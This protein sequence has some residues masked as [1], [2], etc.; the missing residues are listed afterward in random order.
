MKNKIIPT[1]FA[2][3]NKTFNS[4]L[5]KL[6]FSKNIHLDFMDKTFTDNKTVQIKEMK[7]IS[8]YTNIN[9]EIH[10]MTKNPLKY[11]KEIKELNIKKV[12][13][14]EEVSGSEKEI[15][16]TIEIFKKEKFEVFIVLN[17]Q[18][19]TKR[20]LKI[21]NKINGIMLM[22]VNPG[23]EGQKFIE[24][25]YNKIKEIRKIVGEE[26]QIQ[27]DGG[28]NDKNILKLINCSAQ[29]LSV[30][31]NISSSKDPKKSYQILEELIGN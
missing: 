31:S 28:I 1:I 5:E 16:Q 23:K 18:T 12:L 20:I 26:F 3:D 27:I 30:G 14:Q 8:K 24:N 21:I 29:I 7:E 25:T 22:S 2:L 6:K 19:S 15:K 11:L 13:I 10:L 4:K 9:F 17:P